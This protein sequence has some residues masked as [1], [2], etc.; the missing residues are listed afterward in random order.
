[1]ERRKRVTLQEEGIGNFSMDLDDGV[2]P[3]DAGPNW[4]VYCIQYIN[5]NYITTY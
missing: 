1:M 2:G 3:T 4:Q 5:Y